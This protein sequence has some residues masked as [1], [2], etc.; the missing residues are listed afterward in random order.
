M[1][2]ETYDALFQESLAWCFIRVIAVLYRRRDDMN[3]VLES[4]VICWALWMKELLT[5][6]GTLRARIKLRAAALEE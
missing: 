1:Q 2:R 5:R 6:F 4:K 3:S